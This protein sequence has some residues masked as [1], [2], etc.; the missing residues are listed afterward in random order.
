MR[1]PDDA[2][3]GTPATPPER[4]AEP[5]AP[6]EP[7]DPNA[8]SDPGATP[9][10]GVLVRARAVITRPLRRL[11]TRRRRRDDLQARFDRYSRAY[12][13]RWLLLGAAIGVAAGL[14][15]ALFYLAIHVATL[16]L[17]GAVAG[18]IPPEPAGEGATIFTP[19]ARPWLLPV[20]TGLG[21]LLAGLL[22]YHVAPETESGGTDNVL[23]AFHERNGMIRTR[24]AP[25][26]LIAS[27]I[28]IGSGGSAG[29]E[30]AAA[31]IMAS[32]G[33]WLAQALRLDEHDRRIAVVAGM[34]AG[35]GTIFRAPFAGAIFGAEVLYKRDFEA[36]AIFPTFIASV[37]G[38][39]VFGVIVGWEPIFGSRPDFGFHDPR[40]LG[41]FLLLGILAGAVGLLFERAM[42]ATKRGFAWLR[43]PR[44]LKPAIGGVL[45]GLIGIYLPE[46]L[47]MGYGFMQFAVN[48]DYATMG[49][50]TLALLVFAKIATTSLTLGSGGSGGDVAPAMVAGGFMGGA[51][52]AGLHAY[53]PALVVGTQPGA[54]VLVG[55]AAFF[56]GISKT[57]LAMI[58]MVTEMSGELSLIAPAMLATMA[59][60]VMTGDAS[61]Y[62]WQKATRLDSPAHR[63][64]YA[65]A[66]M[67]RV[68]VREALEPAMTAP[69]MTTATPETT[70]AEL[71]AILRERQVNSA[72]VIADGRLAG[73]V[74][75][76]DLLRA[77]RR[78]QRQGVDENGL[79]ARELMTRRLVY[80]S[81]DESLYTAWLRMTSRGL[82]QL[83]VVDDSA[84]RGFLGVVTLTTIREIWRQPLAGVAATRDMT[85]GEPLAITDEMS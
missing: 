70:A 76:R 19:A 2:T 23:E 26:K 31:Q 43:L 51:I 35:I 12:F 56:G 10:A 65:L 41:G 81:P 34:G 17:L 47:G 66:M 20:V 79:P 44:A 4:T 27:A 54:F 60:Y 78:A 48:N 13:Q 62:H 46:S 32:V 61:V 16:L 74:T 28:T 84:A 14:V 1:S 9:D 77:R 69:V 58:L 8:S 75:A 72:P 5:R 7:S 63:D 80:V 53:A 15:M 42:D 22:V 3:G 67:R 39:T 29:R 6:D 59:A 36:D 85:P 50:L 82:R 21:G 57:P 55:M 37:V 25:V 40:S 38:Y 83:A 33:S 64:D 30:G 18:F 11:N 52:W 45:V 71:R 68:T 49:G 24:V 73:L